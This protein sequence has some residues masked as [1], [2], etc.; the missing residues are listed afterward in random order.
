[1]KFK[2]LAISALLLS[3]LISGCDKK[4]SIDSNALTSS[5]Q[6]QNFSFDLKTIDS[7]KIVIDVKNSQWQFANMKNKSVLVVFFATWCPPCK[8]EIP[9]LL[10]LKKQF[11][12][13]FEV[14][15]VLVEE[16][17]K[18]EEIIEFAK[19]HNINYPVTNSPENFVL[20]SAVGGVGT[21]P[22]MF[23]FDKKGTMVQKYEGMVPEEMLATDIA[24]GL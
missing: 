4:E 18:N 2:N 5:T 8:A 6:N 1:M 13:K 17:K 20:A 7:K 3:T 12:D 16:N 19:E 10:N 14:L 15:A 24:K 22:A 21:I 11:G 9:H 23:L